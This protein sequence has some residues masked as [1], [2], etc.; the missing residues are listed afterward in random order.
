MFIA[1]N[2]F[3]NIYKFSHGEKRCHN[4]IP[5]AKYLKVFLMSLKV[6]NILVIPNLLIN[7][8]IMLH[9]GNIQ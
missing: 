2:I 4:N 8:L 9:E 6:L 1:L 3:E 7:Q 5:A